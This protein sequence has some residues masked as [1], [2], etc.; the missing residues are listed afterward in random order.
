MRSVRVVKAM[1]VT[2]KTNRLLRRQKWVTKLIQAVKSI[3]QVKEVTMI[4]ISAQSSETSQA[5][6]PRNTPKARPCQSQSLRI[7]TNC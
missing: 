6:S 5:W 3:S 4:T 7:M 1:M 2:R